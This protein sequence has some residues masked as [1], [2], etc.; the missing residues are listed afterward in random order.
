MLH[1]LPQLLKRLTGLRF[2]LTLTYVVF[3]AVM[4]SVLGVIFRQTIEVLYNAQIRNILNEEW[5]AVR[6]YLRIEKPKGK[7]LP[8]QMNW[9]YDRFDPEEAL[10]GDRLRQVYLIAD[11]QG[12]VR[13]I[14]AK[15]RQLFRESPEQIRDAIRRH[16]Q[17]WR[18]LRDPDGTSY[19]IRTGIIMSVDDQPYYLAIGRSTAEEERILEEFTLL[20]SWLLP[21]MILSTAVMGWFMAGRALRPVNQLAETAQRITGSNLNLQIPSRG[22]GDEIDRLIEAFNRMVE[23]LDESF[24]QTRQFSTDVSHELRTP[25]T[26]IRGQLEVALLAARTPEQYQEAILNALQDVERLS[27]TIRALLLLSQAESGQ[28]TLQKQVVELDSLVADVVEEFQIPAEGVH[29]RLSLARRE[30]VIVVADR[31]QLERLLSNLLSNALKYTPAGGSVAVSVFPSGTDAQMI[32]SDTGVG[33]PAD[34]L[35]YIFD[36][37]Y[38]VPSRGGQKSGGSPEKGLGLGL[39][40]VAWIVKAHGGSVNVQSEPGQ[41]T[42]FTVT[43]PQGSPSSVEMSAS[44]ETERSLRV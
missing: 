17:S 28:L 36:R 40:F 33:I 42:A 34:H 15:Y 29:I 24:T 43:I 5:G 21:L 31:V 20:Y 14:S 6:G 12:V 38:R 7:G 16:E 9:Y 37:F 8:P 26:A 32:V 4:L 2:R 1:S 3:F 19:T 39:S 22:S 23:R 35:P 30:T 10:I 18:T 44:T 25:L 11:A 41:G 13:E 27:K